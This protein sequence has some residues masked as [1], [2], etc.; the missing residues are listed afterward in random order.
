MIFYRYALLHLF[1]LFFVCIF[2]FS[3]QILLLKQNYGLWL[4]KLITM[5][6]ASGELRLSPPASD[7]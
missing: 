7:I 5:I 3:Q 4:L 1:L 6:G 2:E